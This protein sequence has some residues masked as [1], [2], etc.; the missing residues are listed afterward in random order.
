MQVPKEVEVSKSPS[1]RGIVPS[2]P[3]Y[4]D[5][6]VNKMSKFNPQVSYFI[7]R[8]CKTFLTY[9]SRVPQG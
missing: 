4:I 9:Q 1:S 2:S 5:S 7:E 3:E 8:V 6:R